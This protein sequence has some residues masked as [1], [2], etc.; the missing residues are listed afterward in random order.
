MSGH[1]K[2][3]QIKR[4][5][6]V[7]DTKRG[8]MFMRLIREIT[9]ASRLGGA[10]PE[11]NS[12]L[13][14]AIETARKSSMPNDN[15][16]RA[17]ARGSGDDGGS[18]LEEL[19]YEAYG[20]GGVAI[21]IEVATDNR[22]R[23]IGDMRH[24]ITKYGGNLGESG[25]VGWMFAKRGTILIAKKGQSEDKLLTI[26]LEAGADDLS[27]TDPDYYEVSTAPE[28][29]ESVLKVITA[30]GIAIEEEKVGLMASTHTKIG[31]AEAEKVIKLLDA[32]EENDDVQ[33][34]YSNAEFE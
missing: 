12:R 20:P 21:M 27:T 33:N 26:A 10:D 7:T 29:F 19:L 28:Q 15:I 2:W 3:S 1:S 23:T 17:I 11:G 8:L 31:G 30:A 18:T 6:A 16:K 32:L 34:V 13:R 4:K 14:L 24:L 5:K 22:N 9:I 25:S